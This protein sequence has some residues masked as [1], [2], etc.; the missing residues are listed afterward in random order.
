MTLDVVIPARNEANTLGP[1]IETFVSHVGIGQVIVAVDVDTND[2]TWDVAD[3][4]GA[5]RIVTGTYCQGKG[6]AVMY[7]LSTVETDR[8]IMCDADITGL[9]HEHI[10]HLIHPT[11]GMILGVPDWPTEA[12]FEATG[13]P[14]KW[15]KRL[16]LSWA[17]VTGQRAM[18]TEFARDIGELHGYLVDTQM[19]VRAI[20]AGMELIVRELHGLHSPFQLTDQRLAEME[21]DRQWGMANGWLPDPIK[22]AMD[23][24]L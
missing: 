10:N 8:F 3:E 2:D 21:R 13:Q 16:T 20:E 22:D 17:M 24:R 14:R 12:E 19:N 9:T 4:A 11:A 6:Q 15:K 23:R 1:I 18:P 5:S 7:G